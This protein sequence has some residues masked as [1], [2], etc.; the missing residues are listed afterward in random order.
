MNAHTRRSARTEGKG[1]AVH[2]LVLA[3]ALVFSKRA[4]NGGAL[5][6]S[7]LLTAGSGVSI[8]GLCLGVA[9]D[10]KHDCGA[11]RRGVRDERSA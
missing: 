11:G 1:Q 4:A 10:S 5:F 3:T 9:Q 6:R 7:D 8:V 2:A